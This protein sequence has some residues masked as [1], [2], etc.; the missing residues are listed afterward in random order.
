M[1][2]AIAS[3][4]G[5]APWVAFG[6]WLVA[7]TDPLRARTELPSAGRRQAVWVR[8]ALVAAAL[9]GLFV[10][11]AGAIA[12]VLTPSVDDAEHRVQSAA[13][14][15]RSN[16]RDEPVPPR[17][18]M[19]LVAT[20]DSRFYSHHGVDTLGVM[21]ATTGL[22][23]QQE[24]GGSTLDQQLAKLLYRGSN[25]GTLAKV[26]EVGLGVKIDTTY[27]KAQILE[28]YA[29]A[30]YFGHGFYGL[31]DAACGYFNVVPAQL[32]WT[33]A[34]TLAGLVQAPSSYDPIAHPKL[35][36]QRQRHVLDRLVAVGD[37]ALDE[38]SAILMQPLGLNSGGPPVPGCAS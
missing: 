29:Q 38:A 22:L 15:Q 25:P 20:E 28:M 1:Q 35:A 23:Q 24:S 12:L 19:A 9:L 10:V 21:R 32:S 30:A 37:L 27:P 26:E 33:Q 5:D 34:S 13:L 31:H 6:G 36:R 16:D 14:A 4:R 7:V 18:A 17:F 8:R 11:A 2:S 3:V